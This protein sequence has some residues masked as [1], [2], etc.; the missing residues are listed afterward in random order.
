M[1]EI[2]RNQLSQ[3]LGSHSVFVKEYS[4][5]NAAKIKKTHDAVVARTPADQQ[6]TVA[7]GLD[8]IETGKTVEECLDEVLG[9]QTRTPDIPQSNGKFNPIKLLHDFASKVHENYDDLPTEIQHEKHLEFKAYYE[10]LRQQVPQDDLA[11]FDQEYVDL[12]RFG[13]TRRMGD[14]GNSTAIYMGLLPAVSSVGQHI[15]GI[16]NLLS[17]DDIMAKFPVLS[18][19]MSLYDFK[20]WHTRDLA[21][22]THSERIQQGQFRA[23]S[24][25]MSRT[26]F[27]YPDPELK[28]FGSPQAAPE[29]KPILGLDPEFLPGGGDTATY[30]NNIVAQM[31]R[32][33][34]IAAQSRY[35]LEDAD[36]TL[37]ISPELTMAIDAP[38]D[39][40][41]IMQDSAMRTA[42]KGKIAT[43][44]KFTHGPNGDQC[45]KSSDA[46]IELFR[47]QHSEYQN[48]SN[49]EIMKLICSAD[50]VGSN[51]AFLAP[52]RALD[53]INLGM[54]ITAQAN[55]ALHRDSRLRLY[56]PT[57][58]ST[59]VPALTL[60]VA[61][62]F[63]NQIPNL[64]SGDGFDAEKL[65]IDYGLEGLAAVQSLIARDNTDIRVGFGMANTMLGDAISMPRF[66]LQLTD[67]FSRDGLDL[68]APMTFMLG[69]FIVDGLYNYG[70]GI[71]LGGLCRNGID[72][73]DWR[74]CM[75]WAQA[76]VAHI[77]R[78]INYYVSRSPSKVSIPGLSD[79]EVSALQDQYT[80]G[81]SY[82]AS[83]AGEWI[84]TGTF[85]A[86]STIGLL[87]SLNPY[88]QEGIAFMNQ[89]GLVGGRHT[90]AGVNWRVNLGTNGLT[91]SGEF[92]S[93]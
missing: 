50:P 1:G 36:L 61:Q 8:C 10:K 70:A 53:Q 41:K 26:S 32:Y 78:K 49:E 74:Y 55:D 43:T 39:V 19:P 28:R 34:S 71:Q 31:L 5:N 13:F 48:L 25:I 44:E 91:L 52:G 81:R 54:A 21:Q 27:L 37:L 93:F 45:S 24:D 63:V 77:G 11:N 80:A 83:D 84:A 4:E 57:S 56:D 75:P 65:G 72:T 29:T 67:H 88:D 58:T 82:A 90:D 66:Y 46:E 23:I 68:N 60:A 86:G 30:Y 59:F 12:D 76:V 92:M 18:T 20:L 89:G 33:Q 7:K 22:L 38:L 64:V 15:F 62:P 87:T 79:G 2:N 51:Q 35:R 3:I 85:V 40:L 16:Y 73:K 47:I 17:D 6:A 14:F 9:G 69:G 42:A